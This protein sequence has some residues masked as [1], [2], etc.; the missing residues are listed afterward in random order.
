MATHSSVLAW[1]TQSRTQLKQLNSSSKGSSF[2]DNFSIRLLEMSLSM[3]SH[4]T[5]YYYTKF[6]LTW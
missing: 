1:V 5:F 3:I 2:C 4:L 6:S